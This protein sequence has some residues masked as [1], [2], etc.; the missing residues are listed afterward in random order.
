[1]P[2]SLIELLLFGDDFVLAVKEELN[3]FGIN[4]NTAP[5]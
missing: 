1:M 5:E 2:L 4:K 3:S